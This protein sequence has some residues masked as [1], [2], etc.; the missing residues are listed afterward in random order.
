MWFQSARMNRKATRRLTLGLRGL[1]PLYFWSIFAYLPVPIRWNP[2][3]NSCIGSAGIDLGGCRLHF[4]TF[5]SVLG[6]PGENVNFHTSE[7]QKNQLLQIFSK[8]SRH[9]PRGYATKLQKQRKI[10]ILARTIQ[11]STKLRGPRPW[12]KFR[13]ICMFLMYF[14]RVRVYYRALI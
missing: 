5:S 11:F 9:C 7:T 8:L 14:W 4:S 6:F 12:P 10:R 2:P 3:K 13:M 1:S